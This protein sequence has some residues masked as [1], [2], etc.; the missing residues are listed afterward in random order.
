MI[1][2]DAKDDH[3]RIENHAQTVGHDFSFERETLRP[4]PS[5]VF[6]TW[7]TL[8]P[9]VDRYARVTVRQRHYSLPARLIGRRVR[10]HLG[11]QSVVMF[12]GRTEVAR[13]ERLITTGGQS[14]QLDHYL[15]ILQR[16]PGALPGA[17]A[18]VQARAAKVFTPVHDAFWAAARKAG[19]DSAG[20]HALIEVLLLHRH[21]AAADVLAG[22]TAALTV[23][24]INPDVVAV[25][26]RKAAQQRGASPGAEQP[27][28]SSD[29]V[30]NLTERRTAAK[31]PGDGRPLPT[32]DQYDALLL[33]QRQAGSS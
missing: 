21:L 16:K 30:V 29:D 15:E 13:H 9:R 6:P 2:A 25:Q 31:L 11:A 4:W 7:L 27:K 3:R 14:L 8:T 10:V 17:T 12:D 1:T 32:V 22:I 18:L 23:G 28:R 20:T 26:A 19:G 33:L 24:S 5:E